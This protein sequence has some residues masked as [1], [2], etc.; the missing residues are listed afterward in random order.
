[1][2]ASL[3]TMC[4]FMLCLKHAEISLLLPGPCFRVLSVTL[5]L[6]YILPHVVWLVQICLHNVYKVL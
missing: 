5:G 4:E 6:S 1:M 3:D 2:L